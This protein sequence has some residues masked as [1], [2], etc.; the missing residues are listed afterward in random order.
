M[1]NTEA[2]LNTAQQTDNGGSTVNQPTDSFD[3]VMA[4]HSASVDKNA[5]ALLPVRMTV[6]SGRHTQKYNTDPNRPVKKYTPLS[7]AQQQLTLVRKK[8]SKDK[9]SEGAY[10]S[11][12]Y[13]IEL[14]GVR[15][16]Q[17]EKGQQVNL[18]LI[19][20]TVLTG[21]VVKGKSNSAGRFYFPKA[22]IA[23]IE[24]PAGSERSII[25]AMI[26]IG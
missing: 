5:T 13:D 16:A 21:H 17:I 15:I 20:G 23:G 25:V 6:R 26:L 11:S 24:L 12:L 8:G 10:I 22:N 3:K 14:F 9:D 7:G 4:E 18:L 1:E 19:N 2:L